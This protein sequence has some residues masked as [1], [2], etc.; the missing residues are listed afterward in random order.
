M[1]TITIPRIA[2]LRNGKS[3]SKSSISVFSSVDAI[4]REQEPF[5]IV[6]LDQPA[7]QAEVSL[8]L[9]RMHKDYALTLIYC[10]QDMSKM[11]EHLS[12]GKAP[13]SMD[14]MRRA[15]QTFQ[16]RQSTFNRGEAPQS[17][18]WRVMAWMWLRQDRKL[19]PLESPKQ[20]QHYIYPVLDVLAQGE[21]VNTFEW[22][23]GMTEKGV[24]QESGLIDR[25][26]ACVSCSSAR[27]NFIDVCPECKHIDIQRAPS[28]HCYTCGH[29]GEQNDF[30]KGGGIV[31]PHC[32]TKL[33]HI[34]SDY[35]RPMENYSCRRCKAFFVDALVQA[36]CRD[37]GH[38]HGSDDLSVINIK[39]Y[40]LKEHGKLL[41]RH[42]DQ[43]SEG[44][45][46]PYRRGNFISNPHFTD[47]LDWQ[48]QMSKRY[49]GFEFSLVGLKLG[50]L[51]AYMEHV[52]FSRACRFIDHLIDRINATFRDT[53]RGARF[54]ETQMWLVL[55]NTNEDGLKCFQRRL[56]EIFVQIKGDG[57]DLLKIEMLG[58]SSSS[59]V[60]VEEDACLLLSRLQN[61][62]GD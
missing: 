26:R 21:K 6:V 15:V 19:D 12:D 24:F 52:G 45:T 48:I 25:I 59:E 51:D 18:E 46:K 36:N 34:G 50:N 38:S 11:C 31:C 28:L 54:S 53:D 60:V 7:N 33:R 17:F 62:L 10:L 23:S 3:N 55:P 56:G 49:P 47:I 35:D 22:L 40:Q 32:M 4:L 14:A 30:T 27:L 39:N 5:N 2:I 1:P 8:R 20:P 41:C 37:C 44:I 16:D 58:Y 29:V 9:L 42:G 57:T 13:A 43:Y 61:D